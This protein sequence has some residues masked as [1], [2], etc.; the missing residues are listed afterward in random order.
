MYR[1][2]MAA[3][4]L[5]GRWRDKL[6]WE[7]KLQSILASIKLHLNSAALTNLT[8]ILLYAWRMY[9]RNHCLHTSNSELVI[10]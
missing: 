1:Y 4:V 8:L 2:R 3:E 7:F 5:I 10:S 6:L 9:Q